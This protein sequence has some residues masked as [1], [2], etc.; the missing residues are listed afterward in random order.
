MADFQIKQSRWQDN[1]EA[2]RMIRK[3]V[4]MQEQKVPEELEWDGLDNDAI[5]LLARDNSGKPIATARMLADGHIGRVA[6]LPAWRGHGIGS[7]LMQR[8][9]QIGNKRE[10]SEIHLDAQVEAIPFYQRLGFSPH[11]EVFMDAGIPHRHMHRH[12]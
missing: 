1:E 8:L 4:F 12:L 9:I 7:A 11:G 5:H 3:T 10:L 6:V 2:L